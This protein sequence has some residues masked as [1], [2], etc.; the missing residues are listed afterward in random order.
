VFSFFALARFFENLEVGEY[1]EKERKV[2][3]PVSTV[4]APFRFEIDNADEWVAFFIE[5][6]GPSKG[7]S[8]YENFKVRQTA[9][10]QSDISDGACFV[11]NGKFYCEFLKR[12]FDYIFS[13][14]NEGQY[15]LTLQN[16]VLV[17][18]DADGLEISDA[19]NVRVDGRDLTVFG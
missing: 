7:M 11:D 3:K 4:F 17:A 14:P 5:L 8:V 16:L 10:S 1:V 18:D 13:V 9:P 15:R 6:F 12:R 2:S 19:R